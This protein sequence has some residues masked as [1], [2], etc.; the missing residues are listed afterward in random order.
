M[1]VI[2]EAAAAAVAARVEGHTRARSY[3]REV[4]LAAI[5]KVFDCGFKAN[6][7]LEG[8]TSEQV[9]VVVQAL[10]D[11]GI[12][13]GHLF[14]RKVINAYIDRRRVPFGPRKASKGGEGPGSRT[15]TGDDVRWIVDLLAWN[16]ACGVSLS[17]I[18]IFH[19]LFCYRGVIVSDK[20]IGAVLRKLKF[21]KKR[22]Q[23]RARLKYTPLNMAYYHKYCLSMQA[24]IVAMCGQRRL[25]FLDETGSDHHA[26]GGRSFWGPKGQV[27]HHTDSGPGGK[28]L[29]RPLSSLTS[30]A[31]C[32]FW[33]VICFFAS[34]AAVVALSLALANSRLA[35]ASLRAIVGFSSACVHASAGSF[36]STGTRQTSEASCFAFL[37]APWRL[38]EPGA[39]SPGC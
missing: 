24:D 16:G 10:S 3:P 22:A 27:V 35:S 7:Q 23:A 25:R 12:P 21:S 17:I 30:T 2:C 29:L 20:T 9:L 6:E 33:S 14:V 36:S 13:V 11:S 19:A 18:D 28:T 31:A 5:Q 32:F 38:P 15:L 39:I 4:W 8:I 1:D 34:L 37:E 26:T